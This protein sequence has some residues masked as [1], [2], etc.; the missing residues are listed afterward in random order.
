V[1]ETER[2]RK[3][4]TALGKKAGAQTARP[5]DEGDAAMRPKSDHPKADEDVFDR[6][7]A[8]K[9]RNAYSSVLE[10][11]IP[12]DLLRLLQQKLKD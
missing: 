12:D 11:P 10:E 5:T 4:K 7:L 9:L 6:W 3:G 2:G 1:I 8:D